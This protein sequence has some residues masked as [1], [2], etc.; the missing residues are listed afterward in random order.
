MGDGARPFR[1]QSGGTG[2][3]SSP[4]RRPGR[5]RR[6]SRGRGCPASA[7]TSRVRA[8][9]VLPCGDQRARRPAPGVQR[10]RRCPDRRAISPW[11]IGMPPAIWARYSPKPIC[12]ISASISPNWPA[13]SS[14]AGPGLHLAQRF[15]IGGQPGQRVGRELVLFQRR[16]GQTLPAT[17]TSARSARARRRTAPRPRAGRRRSASGVGQ[18]GGLGHGLSIMR[19]GA[20][21]SCSCGIDLG[22]CRWQSNKIFVGRRAR[23]MKMSQ[24]IL[25]RI[26]QD[27]PRGRAV[28]TPRPL[29]RLS[30]WRRPSRRRR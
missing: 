30:R 3:G 26:G 25:R 6:R 5:W 11:L 13:A 21:P 9:A 7:S 12:R 4:A 29:R 23:R 2:R 22:L 14:A 28:D 27:S 1:R 24:P 20:S 15:D 8:A 18:E 16:G 17:V 10:Q 19:H